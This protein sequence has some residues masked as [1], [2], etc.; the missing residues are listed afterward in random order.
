[1][2]YAQIRTQHIAGNPPNTDPQRSS[3]HFE[4][5]KARMKAAGFYPDID[6]GESDADYEARLRS[7]NEPAFTASYAS[8]AETALTATLA[9]SA[10]SASYALS[11]SYAP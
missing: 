4:A 11:A 1:M 6:V 3:E 8:V 5:Y 9:T 10:T 2:T 7:Y